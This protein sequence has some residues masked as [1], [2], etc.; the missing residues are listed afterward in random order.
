MSN[1]DAAQSVIALACRFG[2][3][4]FCV[5]AGARNAPLLAVLAEAKGVRLFSFV[6]ERSAAFFALG[7][8]KLRK[9]PVA[10][11]TTSGTAVAELL[12]ATIEAHYAG[13][14]LLL[15]TADR[16][17]RFRNTGAPQAIEQVGIFTTYV[18]QC[19]DIDAA[20]N[21]SAS[22]SW[23]GRRPLHINVAFDEPLI[24]G[25]IP[26]ALFQVAEP[27][28]S[29]V[30]P[31]SRR[32]I[33]E[34]LRG[35]ARPLVIIGGLLPAARSAVRRFALRLGAPVYAE[36]LSGLREDAALEPLVLRS[37]E[38]ILE[39]AGFDGVLR[40]GQ[41]PALRFW[42]DLEER[43]SALPVVSV[44]ELP[45]GGLSRGVLVQGEI[46]TVLDG[47]HIDAPSP[48]HETMR[49]DRAMALRI[50]E[51]CDREPHSEPAL[52]QALSRHVP[53]QSRIF[54]G[55][56]LPIR[57]WDLVAARE[58]QEWILEANRGA[59]GID[60]ELSTFLG[61]CDRS[62]PNWA[63]V[64]DLT[65]LCDLGAPWIVGQMETDLQFVIVILNN[66]GGRIFSRV[67]SLRAIDPRARAT[68]IE[69][70]H[71]IRFGDWATMWGL[72]Y[73][74]TDRLDSLPSIERGVLEVVVDRDATRRFW[75][76]YDRLWD[77]S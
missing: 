77:E 35:F 22:P 61:Q 31:P 38:R 42:R 21:E 30:P 13:V 25:P 49:R 11:I 40:I 75:T 7:R 36:P 1:L 9:R 72:Q 74:V 37:G 46:S 53:A 29:R 39:R 65:T 59:N 33:D 6:D 16:P 73:A 47:V 19:V 51:L 54:L 45:F 34:A 43:H 44:S 50:R 10:I 26:T 20:S 68:L 55:N 48:N 62:S 5:C 56:S 41:V 12:P 66:G 57:E 17:R 67:A 76:A 24:D 64:G 52:V 4:D 18:E 27:V 23:S 70:E 69:N 2:A 58:P 63:I 15:I 71:A 8:A 3:Y 14:P 28:Q 32:P 60:G